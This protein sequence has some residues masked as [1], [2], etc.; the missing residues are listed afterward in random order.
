MSRKRMPWNSVSSGSRCVF[1]FFLIPQF[2]SAG[3]KADFQQEVNTTL[4]VTLDDVH[5][6]LSGTEEIE[7]I[8]HSPDT[9]RL[10][11]FHLYPTLTVTIRQAWQA[12]PG[13]GR[14]I[15]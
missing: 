3:T 8:N 14:I 7:Y 13:H 4:Q 9:L 6:V 15:F 12:I 5:H 2:A 1:L 10:L 11:F